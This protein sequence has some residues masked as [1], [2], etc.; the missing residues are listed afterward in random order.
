MSKVEGRPWVPRLRFPEFWDDGE[1]IPGKLGN[2]LVL[3]YGKS[4]PVKERVQGEFP[5]YGSN[6]IVGTHNEALVGEPGIVIGRKGSAGHVHLSP[7]PFCPIDTTFFITAHD[8]PEVDLRF[9]YFLLRHAGLKGIQ[10]AGSVPGLSREIAYM[11]K[12]LFPLSRKEQQRIAA[13]LSSLDELI[14]A[15]TRKVDALKDYKKGLMQQLFPQ[16][17]ETVPRLR[18]PEYRDAGEWDIARLGDK[19]IS[20]FVREKLSLSELATETYVSTENLLPDYGGVTNVSGLP[21]SGSF[22]KYRNA[23]I[24]ISNIRP[25]LKKVWV[26]D[27]NGGSSNDVVVIRAT[28]RLISSFLAL[29]LKNDDFIAYIMRGAKGV[30]MP[31]GD[32][33]LMKEYPLVFPTKE[34]QQE[35]AACLSSL[36]EL[37]SAQSRRLD[38][39]RTHK[40][41][42]MQQLFPAADASPR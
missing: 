36:D 41:G 24:L 8:A 4:L 9:L 10:D 37:I 33:S 5:V 19:D 39:L 28:S 35:I 7:E 13:C 38:A 27:R 21:S 3:N 20:S 16:E 2:V 26:S 22:T 30:K 15:Q 18:F 1:W 14:S 40:K 31:R 23:D 11:E 6:G 25:Y 12:V 32:I 42:L 29:Q 17:G 34:E